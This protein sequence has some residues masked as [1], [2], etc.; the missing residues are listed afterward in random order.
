MFCQMHFEGDVHIVR[1]QNALGLCVRG[2]KVLC[3]LTYRVRE[4]TMKLE[5][6]SK[7]NRNTP[8]LSSN[9]QYGC[10]HG[11]QGRAVRGNKLA[12]GAVRH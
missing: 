6:I 8:P 12:G 9:T 2:I 7:T 1:T 11:W 5:S 4:N 3:D 10:P